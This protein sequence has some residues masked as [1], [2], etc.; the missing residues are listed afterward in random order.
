MY[1]HLFMSLRNNSLF[2][3]SNAVGI[4]RRVSSVRIFYSFQ[5]TFEIPELFEQ[6]TTVQCFGKIEFSF[7]RAS[8]RFDSGGGGDVATGSSLAMSYRLKG[9]TLDISLT[10]HH[11]GS[12]F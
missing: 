12:W 4:Y 6:P 1:D 3:V 8:W 11:G 7:H 10:V 2:R 9:F 5:G